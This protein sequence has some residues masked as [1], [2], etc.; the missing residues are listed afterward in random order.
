[1]AGVPRPARGDRLETHLLWR[2]ARAER[3]QAAGRPTE[4]IRHL[5]AGMAHLQR[6]RTQLGSLDLQTG[7]AVHGR[8]IAAAGLAA[9]LRDGSVAAVHRWSELSRAQAL[10]LPPATPPDDPDAAAA[11]EEL[12]QVREGL[13]AAE[14]SGR[15]VAELRARATRLERAVREQSWTAAGVGAAARPAPLDAVRSG[16]GA[17][18][19]VALVKHGPRLLA[20][21]A[22]ER[23]TRILALGDFAPIEE[24]VRRLRA[25]L[26]ARAGRALTDRL[27]Q[28]IAGATHRDAAAV[29]AAL[30]EPL[31]PFVGDRDLVVVPTGTLVAVP[32]GALP[33]CAGRAVTVAPSSTAWLAARRRLDATPPGA[34]VALV[35]GPGND[36]GEAEV[37][38]IARL[39]RQ[40]RLLTG[41]EATP[42]ATAKLLAGAGLAHVAA[43]GRHQPQNALFS[44]L[45]LAGGPLMG[46]DLQRLDAAPTVV[47]LAACDVGLA[48]VRPGDETI[49][50]TAALLATGTST[51]IAG[52]GRVAD[53]ASITVMTGLHRALRAGRAPAAA[54][55]E[56]ARGTPFVCFGAG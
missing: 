33:G 20:L 23:R 3:A 37:R 28:A 6:R 16:L 55:A 32:W 42:A 40:P 13:R 27:D 49:G 51:V 39:Y 56:A 36:L 22:T 45:D 1:V 52:V 35:A 53:Q 31:L 48:D 11:L 8:E 7:A 54:L 38:V 50:M 34:H 2:L 5:A 26:D 41:P 15:P 25:D 4:A 46:Y 17:A 18:A 44:S 9:A 14:L 29:A 47:V 30:V 19:L 24:S 10:L 12:R 21:V 43:H